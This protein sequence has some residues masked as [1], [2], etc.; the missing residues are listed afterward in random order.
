M[1]VYY[2][3]NTL[4]DMQ[5][6]PRSK[7]G[8]RGQGGECEDADITQAGSLLLTCQARV[9]I[10]GWGQVGDR[11]MCPMLGVPGGGSLGAA[12]GQGAQAAQEEQGKRKD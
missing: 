6:L 8:V 11:G 2:F 10:S 5:A 7:L 1:L 9:S 12:R 4:N 3:K